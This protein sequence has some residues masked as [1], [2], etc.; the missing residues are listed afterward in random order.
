VG[1]G[2]RS[3]DAEGDG[4]GAHEGGDGGHH[5]GAETDEASFNDGV[6]GRFFFLMDRLVGKIDHHN[7][8]FQHNSNEHDETDEGIDGESLMEYGEG[9]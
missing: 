5:D 9:E 2:E 8:V 3:A 7:P 6:V 4:D 1:L